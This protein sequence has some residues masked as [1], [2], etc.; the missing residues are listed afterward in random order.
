MLKNPKSIINILIQN[1][2]KISQKVSQTLIFDQKRVSL[3]ISDIENQ[4]NC[5]FQPQ[6]ITFVR[7]LLPS[8]IKVRKLFETSNS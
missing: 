4:T 3:E 1:T 8:I 2:K 7:T 5:L 6:Y